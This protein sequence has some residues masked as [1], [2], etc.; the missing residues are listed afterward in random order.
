MD[1]LQ[2]I[3]IQMLLMGAFGHFFGSPYAILVWQFSVI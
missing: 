2:K 3:I 1:Y